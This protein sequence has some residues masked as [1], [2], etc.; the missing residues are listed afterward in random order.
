MPAVFGWQGRGCDGA[1]GTTSPRPRAPS[2][3]GRVSEAEDG[4]VVV[5][6]CRAG[7]GWAIANRATIKTAA[8]MTPTVRR[9]QTIARH[10]RR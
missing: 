10:P 1:A 5:P 9:R 4:F 8:P 6:E 3:S 2:T 7:D